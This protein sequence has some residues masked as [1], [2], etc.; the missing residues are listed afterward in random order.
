MHQRLINQQLNDIDDEDSNPSG[1]DEL[2]IHR[3]Y[4]RPKIVYDDDT[5][6]SEYV[7]IRL[8]IAR[9]KAMEKYRKVTNQA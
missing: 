1:P 5:E 3:A 6:L 4:S 9:L 2:N 8:L 7:Q